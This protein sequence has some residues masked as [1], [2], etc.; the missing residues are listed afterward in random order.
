M[1]SQFPPVRALSCVNEHHHSHCVPFGTS[2]A[3]H[4]LLREEESRHHARF[5]P[6]LW[7]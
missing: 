3:I 4:V 6:F 5:L 2:D 7:R 1:F